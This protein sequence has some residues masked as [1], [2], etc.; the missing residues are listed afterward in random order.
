MKLPE[1]D[2]ARIDQEKL[3][4]YLLSTTHSAAKAKARFFRSHGFDESNAD[5]LAAGLG[6]IARN[7]QVTKSAVSDFG[8]KYVADGPLKTPMGNR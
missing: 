2:R 3:T 7:E 5:W 1:A 6:E 4:A 8:M